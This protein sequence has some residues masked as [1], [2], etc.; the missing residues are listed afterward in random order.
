MEGQAYLP[1]VL[2][3]EV[4]TTGSGSV[5]LF[6]TV[7][8]MWIE[9][10]FGHIKEAFDTNTTVDVGDEDA[11]GKFIANTEWTESTLNQI[12]V[13]TQTTLPD[14][15]YYSAVKNITVTVGGAGVTAG[16]LVLLFYVW[17]LDDIDAKGYHGQ[18]TVP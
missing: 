16:T 15:A 3:Y 13:S 6:S 8:G 9:K 14:G 4:E 17:Y 7:P 2:A 18:E 12:G 11:A 10:V 1:V 5:T